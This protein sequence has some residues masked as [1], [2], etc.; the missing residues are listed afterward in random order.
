MKL[1]KFKYIVMLPSL[2]RSKGWTTSVFQ[3]LLITQALSG[4]RE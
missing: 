1:S 3:I 4:L 2:D